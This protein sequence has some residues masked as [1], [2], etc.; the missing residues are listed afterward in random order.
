MDGLVW[1]LA[2]RSMARYLFRYP[3]IV[4]VHYL[5]RSVYEVLREIR[6]GAREEV[7]GFMVVG[8]IV[9]RGV[10]A[11]LGAPAFPVCRPVR[12]EEQVVDEASED[13]VREFVWVRAGRPYVILCGTADGYRDGVV[14][15]VKTTR[16]RVTAA[17]VPES[18]RARAAVYGFL[19]GAQE[20]RL[21]IIN[22][23]D[24]TEVD[25]SVEPMSYGEVKRVLTDWLLGS[26]PH[27]RSLDTLRGRN[28]RAAEKQAMGTYSHG[29]PAWQ[30]G[31]SSRATAYG[32]KRSYYRS[33]R[34]GTGYEP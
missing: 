3:G 9:H 8:E 11:L 24:G 32:S 6:H 4:Y 25:V 7:N 15:E 17:S 29:E 5:E 27:P 21:V 31:S 13:V 12:V 30:G 14:Y 1:Q 19:Y 2:R 28:I 16:K 33:R 20:A 10:E 18:W 22:V 34:R 23:V 26:Y